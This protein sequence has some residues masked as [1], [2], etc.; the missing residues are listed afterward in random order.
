[1]YAVFW[2]NSWKVAEMVTRYLFFYTA[3]A[4]VFQ[5]YA[6]VVLLILLSYVELALSVPLLLTASGTLLYV[7]FV[8]LYAFHIDRMGRGKRGA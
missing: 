2:L 5:F 1:M 4:A 8:V 3:R 6:F 7:I